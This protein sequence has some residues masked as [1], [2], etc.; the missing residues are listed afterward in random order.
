MNDGYWSRIFVLGRSFESTLG[1]IYLGTMERLELIPKRGKLVRLLVGA[2]V[3]VGLG[4]VLLLFPQAFVP[5]AP[6]ARWGV[7]AIAIVAILFFGACG[8]FAARQFFDRR[9]RLVLDD[10]GVFDRTLG[11]AVIP[12]REIRGAR[13]V[14]VS[15]TKFISLEL[16]DEERWAAA[17]PGTKRWMGAAN[18]RL[19]FGR[20]NLNLSALDV[21]AEE[22]LRVIQKQIG[23]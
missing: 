23:S 21:T 10:E 4:F 8:V 20:F 19:G 2:L 6:W 15:N 1:R 16:A 17:M 13:I 7:S 3:F 14:E 5:D 11:T 12:W 9:P 18:Q 22:I